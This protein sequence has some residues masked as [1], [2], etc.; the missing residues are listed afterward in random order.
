MHVHDRNHGA[1][2][3]SSWLRSWQEHKSHMDMV[4]STEYTCI[5]RYLGYCLSHQSILCKNSFVTCF[6]NLRHASRP[7]LPG[8]MLS[9]TSSRTFEAAWTAIQALKQPWLLIVLI[10]RHHGTRNQCLA[11]AGGYWRRSWHRPLAFHSSRCPSTCSVDSCRCSRHFA[12]ETSP[13][14]QGDRDR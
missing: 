2:R 9:K 1:S 12:R 5:D 11:D 3:I 7:S 8:E 13:A 14:G 4:S 10:H 6:H